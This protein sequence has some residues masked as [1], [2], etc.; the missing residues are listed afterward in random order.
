MLLCSSFCG[1]VLSVARLFHSRYI[2][3]VAPMC[4]AGHVNE[5]NFVGLSVSADNY[6]ACGSEDNS[7]VAYYAALPTPLA[8][9]C[10]SGAQDGCKDSSVRTYA[11]KCGMDMHGKG[12]C[13]VDVAC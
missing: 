4:C 9:H 10:F 2:T 7:V 6:I 8:R 5:R 3:G 11:V 13:G 12:W 1:Y